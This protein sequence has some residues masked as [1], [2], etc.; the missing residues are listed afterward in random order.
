[1]FIMRSECLSSLSLG[2][3]LAALR[4]AAELL[5]TWS[6]LLILLHP[7]AH[8]HHPCG[9]PGIGLLSQ[10]IWVQLLALT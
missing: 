5:I 2:L 3:S 7:T 9:E 6:A 4:A 8:L 10:H 1:M